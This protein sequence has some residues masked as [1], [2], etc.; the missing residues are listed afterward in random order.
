MF[1]F[2]FRFEYFKVCFGYLDF[3][4]YGNGDYCKFGVS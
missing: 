1:C 3:S 2:L 4:G